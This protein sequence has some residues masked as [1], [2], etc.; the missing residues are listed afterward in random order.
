MVEAKFARDEETP[1]E[2]TPDQETIDGRRRGWGRDV[3]G[4]AVA[5]SP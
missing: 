3:S 5:P 1:D 2:E 4:S